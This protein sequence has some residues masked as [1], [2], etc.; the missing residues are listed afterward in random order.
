MAC[1]LWDYCKQ[2]VSRPDLLKKIAPAQLR[3]ASELFTI[4]E[5]A[6][7]LTK[8]QDYVYQLGSLASNPQTTA[9]L[10]HLNEQRVALEASLAPHFASHV[11]LLWHSTQKLPD[12]LSGDALSRACRL[13]AVRMQTLPSH[14]PRQQKGCD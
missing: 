9:A 14:G 3:L 13:A 12:L 11:H 6:G 7:F 10:Q 2:V 1:R 8:Q 5:A 4:L